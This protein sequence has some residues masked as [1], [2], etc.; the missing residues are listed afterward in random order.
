MKY[1]CLFENFYQ[2][3]SS[4]EFFDVDIKKDNSVALNDKEISNL[5]EIFPE[6]YFLRQ[7]RFAFNMVI[8]SKGTKDICRFY[9]REDEWYYV[10]VYANAASGYYKCDQFDGLIEYLKKILKDA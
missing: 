6:Y 3:I 4:D 7:G 9:K 1:L 2:N 8:V 5:I 10:G